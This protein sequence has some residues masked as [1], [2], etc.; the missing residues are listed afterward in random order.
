MRNRRAQRYLG[1]RPATLLVFTCA[2]SAGAHAGLVPAHLN[3]EPT[4]GA[5]FLVAVALLVAAATAVAAR[6]GDRR[7]TNSAGLLFAGLM[8]AYL[9][10][11]T[12]GIPL[13]D[14][15][16]EALDAVGIATT[17]VEAVGVVVALWLIHPVGRHARPTR[18]LGVS[19]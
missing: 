5:A 18:L 17:S 1:S 11:R 4:L 15:E 16:P 19:Q 10:S 8:L 13:L 9:A 7:F 12:T 6:P 3:G 14:P 2:A